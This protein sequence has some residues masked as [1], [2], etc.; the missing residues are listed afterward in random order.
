[1]TEILRYPTLLHNIEGRNISRE[2][3]VNIVPG[4]GQIPVYH[5]NE[6]DLEALSFPKSILMEKI[7]LIHTEMCIWLYPNMHIQ[8]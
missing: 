2:E 4:E 8:D 6:E 5:S 3:A 7:I 1:M